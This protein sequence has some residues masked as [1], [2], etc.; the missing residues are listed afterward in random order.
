MGYRPYIPQT[1]GELMDQLASMML[2]AP[3]FKDKTGYFPGRNIETEFLAL[4]EGLQT[5]RKKLGEERYVAMRAMSD[6]MRVLFESDPD[7]TNGGAKAGRK[8]IRD[9]EDMLRSTRRP[10]AAK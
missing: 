8:I 1:T 6:Q 7:N 5:L 9:M 3:T 2:S 10:R 4:N